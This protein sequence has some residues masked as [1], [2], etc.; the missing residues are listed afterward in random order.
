MEKICWN[1]KC[2][3][4]ALVG[5][6]TGWPL[7]SGGFADLCNSCG[8]AYDQMKFCEIFH[9]DEDGWKNCNTCK[10]RLHC[11]CI[12]SIHSF[13]LLDA[14]GIE[15]MGCA[16]GSGINPVSIHIQQLA[17]YLISSQRQ[18]DAP[19]RTLNDK[20]G[21]RISQ[22]TSTARWH[23]I[24]TSQLPLTGQA[25]LSLLREMHEMDKSNDI[26]IAEN[27]MGEN[28]SAS[29]LNKKDDGIP[30]SK[31]ADHLKLNVVEYSGE[32]RG[33]PE[34]GESGNEPGYSRK[35]TAQRMFSMEEGQ[36]NVTTDSCLQPAV[37][38][39]LENHKC[40]EINSEQDDY[41]VLTLDN[42]VLEFP[43][44][45]CLNISIGSL[46]S[47][48]AVQTCND[49][50]SVL[51]L[52]ILSGSS[53]QGII[54][55]ANSHHQQQ[56]QVLSRSCNPS[57]STCSDSS[58]D[59]NTQIRFA[60]PPSEGRGRNQL[61]PRYWPRSTDQ[62]LQLITGDSN[63][64]ITPLFEKTLSASDAGRIGRLVLPKA[65]AEAYFPPISQPEGV[66][67]AVQ[68][69]KGKDWVFQFRYWPNNNSRMYV[70]EGVTQCIQA[71]QLQ[72]GDTVTF[73][74][75]D[76]EG[77][78]V[79]GYRKAS[80][81]TLTQEGQPSTSGIGPFFSSALNSGSTE[82]F[83]GYTLPSVNV[84]EESCV[85][86]LTGQVN[87]SATSFSWYKNEKAGGK[88]KDSSSQS[89][90]TPEKKKS[91]NLC[92]KSKRLCIDNGDAFELKLAW[93]EAQ[94]LLH[95]PPKAVPS[96]V[97]IEGHEFEEYEEPPVLCKRTFFMVSQSGEQD[98]WAQCDACG[99]WRRLPLDV[100]LPRRW[101][102]SDNSWDPKRASCSAPQEI[103]SGDFEDLL[104]SNIASKKQ[105]C[106][107][108]L[109]GKSTSSGLHTLA[110]AVVLDENGNEPPVIAQTTKHPR[111]RPGCTCIV[112]IQP[113]SGKGP[114]HKPTCTCNVCMT[115]KRRFKTLMMRR[116]KRQSEREAENARKRQVPMKEEVD[117]D[118][119]SKGQSMN[120]LL[121]NG[122]RQGDR[123]TIVDK[124]PV[125][126]VTLPIV[127]KFPVNGVTLPIVD[128]FPVNGVT[129]PTCMNL[130]SSYKGNRTNE[131][132][133]V[134]SK[135]Q[136]DLN[137]HPAREDEL[138][139][140]VGQVSMLRL[141][142]DAN[143]PLDIY[144]KQQG[145]QGLICQPGSMPVMGFQSH[146]NEQR[147]DE[148]SYNIPAVQN[149]E[150]VNEGHLF[151][152]VNEG[153]VLAN[154]KALEFMNEK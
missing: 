147:L 32:S 26:D 113:P 150:H 7:R 8:L 98:Q 33:F 54:T 111:H 97:M 2:R 75:M 30:E 69:A 146:P 20:M 134:V 137:C 65:C 31:G 129:L 82:I 12:A 46:A 47:K 138:S 127:D 73:S 105:K 37:M 88:S 77:K 56:F 91:R 100:N 93:E 15:C 59:I 145:F 80:N 36:K 131:E 3:G 60:R 43:A 67:L 58:K 114:K 135:S 11:G 22:N 70:L 41:K 152:P 24:P 38:G 139:G 99:S 78:L 136:I 39:S 64:R 42:K 68:D 44:M 28:F 122:S 45:T 35:E 76:L 86:P 5:W 79:M 89:L 66:P 52:G 154:C 57:P 126:G 119:A 48:D 130:Q 74:R 110:N 120:Q 81:S 92:A 128:K 153:H 6:R 25:D 14:G 102:C 151:L 4:A 143:L 117:V 116:K 94:D 29:R 96:I 10:K 1:A 13:T 17:P 63:S 21:A 123:N 9:T 144:L 19:L 103:S 71:M 115:V 40:E 149:A 142:Q 121:E 106:A 34:A 27:N 148:Q 84:K 72:A 101:T 125:S 95:P 104:R 141:L 18:L 132:E 61:L 85:E 53:E 124:F 112:C 107:D 108:G 51:G 23:H 62:E 49:K 109:K 118:P 83:S 50:S 90:L 133:F 87:T 55:A 16:K 140:G